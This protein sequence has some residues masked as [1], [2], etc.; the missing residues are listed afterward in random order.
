MLDQKATNEHLSSSSPPPSFFLA[1]VT[2]LHISG[3]M[4]AVSGASFS[5]FPPLR[6]GSYKHNTTNHQ[7][8]FESLSCSLTNDLIV[9]IAWASVLARQTSNDEVLFGVAYHGRRT[10]AGDQAI[11]PWRLRI[12]PGKAVADALVTAARYN[13]E[14]QQFERMG[15]KK[16]CTLSPEHVRLCQFG[17]LLVLGYSFEDAPGFQ[18]QEYQYP[19]TLYVGSTRV[20]ASFDPAFIE[21]DTV[22]M[23]LIYLV[24][25]I[26][27]GTE[28]PDKI[29]RD[30]IVGTK[31]MALMRQWNA[32][33][34]VESYDAVQVQQLINKQCTDRPSA[35]AV[36][37]WDGSLTYGELNQWASSFARNLTLRIG[38]GPG[39]FVGIFMAKSVRTVVAMLGV[40][41]AG[42]AFIFLPLSLP[43]ERLRT[44][45]RIANV[46]CV[47]T[48]PGQSCTTA[49]FA[50]P[51]LEIESELPSAESASFLNNATASDPL[52]AVFTS[53]STGQPKGIAVDRASFGPGLRRLCALSRLNAESRVFHAASHTFVVSIIEQLAALATGACLCVPSDDEVQNDLGSALTK[54]KATWTILTPSVARLLEPANVP[55]MKSLLLAGEPLTAVDLAQ[56]SGSSSGLY[57]LWGQSESASTLLAHPLRPDSPTSGLGTPTI[58]A[59]WVVDPEDHHRLVPLGAEGELLLESPALARGYLEDSLQTAHT[60]VED[61]AW[62]SDIC[63]GQTTSEMFPRRWL[64]T[65]DLV[66]YCRID[67]S[68]QLVGRKGTR[69]KIR[70]QRVELGEI[71]S[72][73]RKCLPG[74]QQVVAELVVPASGPGEEQQH[75]PMLVA[76]TSTS[77]DKTQ[78]SGQELMAETPRNEH[79][80][81]FRAALSV[82]RQAL[83]SYMVPS[84]ILPLS[85]LPRTITGKIDRKSLREWSGRQT[86]DEILKFHQERAVFRAPLTEGER[87]VQ[88]SCEEVLHLVPGSVGLEDNFFGLGGNSLTAQQ[89]AAATRSRGLRIKVTDVFEKPSLGSLAATG[90]PCSFTLCAGHKNRL[91][92]A[93][94]KHPFVALKKDLLQN[95][96]LPEGYK[97]EDV[98]DVYPALEMQSLLVNL[99]VIDYFPIE[100]NG[101][102][103]YNRLWRACQLFVDVQPSFR[104]IFVSFQGRTMQIVLRKIEIA[105][106][107]LTMPAG[108]DLMASARSWA[109]QDRTQPR[110]LSQPSAAFTLIHG[111]DGQRSAFILKMPHAQYDGVCL[112]QI[113]QQLGE[114]YNDPGLAVTHR[115]LANFTT[116]RLACARLRTPAALNF[117]GTLLADSEVTRLPRVSAGSD[118]SIIYSC[119]CEPPLPPTGIT[120]A[121]AIKAAWAF[122]LAQET[123]STDVVFGQI[124]N[125]RG[126][127]DIGPDVGGRRSGQDIIGMC[128][129]TTPVRVK[130]ASTTRIKQLLLAVQEEHVR[131]LPYETI[132]WFD[133]V[134]NSTPWPAD[135]DL[136]SVVLHEN[137]S[138]AGDLVLGITAGRMDNPIFTTPGWKRHVLV[139]WPRPE[140]LMTFLMTREGAL[141][142]EYAEG[143]V[144]KFNATLMRFLEDP[145]GVVGGETSTLI[146]PRN[147]S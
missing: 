20:L 114:L 2:V 93:S 99:A 126:N 50:L 111:N 118:T 71:E 32:R 77:H 100:V 113:I 147:D 38:I 120:M 12:N 82:L 11:L 15:L 86:L 1:F 64:L 87:I 78:P 49:H 57:S 47:V 106:N 41:R 119:E 94:D 74:V 16:F 95:V 43:H 112:R 134:A 141:E 132:D 127:I 96:V 39:S 23:M 68:L 24:D 76:F 25:F 121:T 8:V 63:K 55:S 22:R 109:L 51:V 85:F 92:R 48:A 128:L 7:L 18:T 46:Q 136:D 59:C 30:Q 139:T 83:P 14:M 90:M 19:L 102:I 52:Y 107:Q 81:A 66:R 123:S 133:M 35:A 58:G 115:T 101:P 69:T 42:A 144:G 40:M 125:C 143:L 37:A 62:Y 13:K 60:F 73:L 33:R 105:W 97:P 116:Y 17:N 79:R 146:T 26:Q 137:F 54:F 9:C 31:G 10:E 28:R 21:S 129:N 67:G 80:S 6:N 72:Q 65:G 138:S 34:E 29:I 56:W 45:C 110:A 117:W 53:G 98:E 61:P 140:R 108:A 84:A 124:T 130:L 122:V 142:K 75:P 135:T 145:E 131:M 4:S 70:G 89:L 91:D 27:A 104:S 88:E 3:A 36:C 44:M 5:Q 103:D